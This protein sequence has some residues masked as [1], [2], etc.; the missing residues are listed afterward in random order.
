LTDITGNT[1]LKEIGRLP[2]KDMHC[3][4]LAAAAV[5]EALS[6]YMKQHRG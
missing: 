2:G 3:T 6:N 1:I 4:E 5:Q